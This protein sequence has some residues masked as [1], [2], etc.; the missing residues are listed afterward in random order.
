MGRI[1]VAIVSIFALTSL[2]G[3]PKA[4]NVKNACLELNRLLE[5]EGRLQDRIPV[6][7]DC[8]SLNEKFEHVCTQE[9][10]DFALNFINEKADKVTMKFLN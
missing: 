10:V 3:C 2:I 9:E 1:A 4:N 5:C 6:S 7:L 8:K